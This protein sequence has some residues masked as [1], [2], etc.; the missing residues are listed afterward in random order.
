MQ[1]MTR[2][3]LL[4]DNMPFTL[5]KCLVARYSETENN[6]ENFVQTLVEFISE[7]KEPMIVEEIPPNPE[8]TR[9][10]EIEVCF[11]SFETLHTLFNMDHFIRDPDVENRSKF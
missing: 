3:L 5:V 8:E 2:K 1:A 11:Q 10:I 6:E 7:I 9:R 4:D